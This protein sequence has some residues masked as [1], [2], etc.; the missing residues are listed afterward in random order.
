MLKVLITGSN[1]FIARN[2]ISHLS[3]LKDIQIK[4]FV[5]ENTLEDLS[6]IISNIDFVFHFAGINRSNRKKD[7]EDV[8]HL[9]T[10]SLCKKLARTNRKIPLI[11]ASSTQ[12]S[13]NNTY[14]KTKLSAEKIIKNYSKNTKS[15]VYI[16][17]FPNLF[18]KWCKPNYNSVV[19]TFC[20]NIANNL[21]I[22]IHDHNHEI[23]LM[24]IDDVISEFISVLCQ[25]EVKPS[26]NNIP[27]YS[28]SLGNLAETI[29]EFHNNRKSLVVD[30][31]G[32]GFL[33]A[34]YATYLSYLKPAFFSYNISSFDDERGRF[35]EVL[36][37]KDSGQFSFFTSKPGEVRGDHY[38]H[39]K[40][41]KFLVVSGEAIFKFRNIQTNEL[42]SVSTNGVSL[43]IVET[44]P[45][46]AHSIEN[47]GNSEMLVILWANEVFNEE[48]SDTYS[49]LIDNKKN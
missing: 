15:E 22:E 35:A 48:K 5:R 38:H 44:I 3:E 11:F 49:Y 30:Q 26:I 34:M 23:K 1:G 27:L 31:V 32:S 8:N 47:I 25:L 39:T 13:E 10:K 40:N 19:A 2:L 12:A 14:G 28:I 4:C 46:W 29:N 16:Y 36:K 17:R 20:N 43:R 24:Y 18:G 33:R 45:G 37:T 7:F 6:E 21:P 9:L 42:Y 41:E